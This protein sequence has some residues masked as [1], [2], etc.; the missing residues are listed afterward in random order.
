MNAKRGKVFSVFTTK[1]SA[2]HRRRRSLK[3]RRQTQVDGQQAIDS[4]QEPEKE[5]LKQLKQNNVPMLSEKP[6]ARENFNWQD[7]AVSTDKETYFGK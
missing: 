3:D 6:G 4:L 7:F 1:I 2:I 5:L